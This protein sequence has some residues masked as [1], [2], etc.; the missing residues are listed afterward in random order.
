MSYK[1]PDIEFMVAETIK[2]LVGLLDAISDT[3]VTSEESDTDTFTLNDGTIIALQYGL[4]KPSVST[5]VIIRRGASKYTITEEN[6]ENT[7]KRI[8]K[9]VIDALKR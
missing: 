2:G 3:D 1:K 5:T 8:T 6:S 7:I 9:T 4:E